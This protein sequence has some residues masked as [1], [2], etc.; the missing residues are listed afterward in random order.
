MKLLTISVG[1][2][3]VSVAHCTVPGQAGGSLSG[4]DLKMKAW[5]GEVVSRSAPPR[6][7][8]ARLFESDVLAATEEVTG[9]EMSLKAKTRGGFHKNKGKESTH[10][11][12]GD[13]I[14]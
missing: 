12:V 10:I 14:L 3:G 13:S 11:S 9:K 4:G 1:R 7:V 5:D 2:L 6:Y 8:A